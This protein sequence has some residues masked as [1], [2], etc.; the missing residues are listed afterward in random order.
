MR[1]WG[2]VVTGF[3][4]LSVILLLLPGA[5]YLAD[6]K[7]E[8]DFYFYGEWLLWLGILVLVA[9][10]AL[11]LSLPVERSV[12]LLR[13]RRSLLVSAAT[14][15]LMLA[16]LTFAGIW[17]LGAGIM[18][19]SFPPQSY[20]GW[21]DSRVKLIGWCLLL[22]LLWGLIFALY[23]QERSVPLT[24]F[25]SWLLK[26]SVLELL[27]AVPAHVV[28]RQ[29]EDCSA[30]GVTALGVTTGIAVMLMSF[31]PGV[32]LLYKKRI[33]TYRRRHGAQE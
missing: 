27:I 16:L 21:I 15:A 24:R 22:W 23:L 26:G 9:G 17:S 25:V 18:G 10:E 13:P 5:D 14:T 19:D 2:V 4:A 33:D 6:G 12:R 1:R 31:G 7:L 29:R 20:Q 30:P 11:L 8:P 3:Y 28:T 32:L